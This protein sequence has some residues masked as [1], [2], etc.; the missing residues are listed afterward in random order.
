[1]ILLPVLLRAAPCKEASAACSGSWVQEPVPTQQEALQARGEPAEPKAFLSF[2]PLLSAGSAVSPAQPEVVRRPSEPASLQW[3]SRQSV[4][5]VD[6][7]GDVGHNPL[8]R[9]LQPLRGHRAAPHDAPV[10][11]AEVSQAQHLRASRQ[12]VGVREGATSEGSRGE[13]VLAAGW[14]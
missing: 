12:C 9:A 11:A 4:Q 8:K 1:M 6:S 7:R 14:R 3:D 10:P 13:V 2:Q 5:H